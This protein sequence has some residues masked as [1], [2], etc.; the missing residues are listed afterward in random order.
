[1]AL[2]WPVE[3]V[4]E[5]P[6]TGDH[7]WLDRALD[8]PRF[9]IWKLT[10]GPVP[11]TPRFVVG[12]GLWGIG[13]ATQDTVFHALIS[14]YLPQ[15]RRATA[16]GLFDAVRGTAWLAGSVVLGL[17]YSVS[18]PGLVAASLVLQLAAL[19]VLLLRERH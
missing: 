15:D 6:P 1:M 19:P 3:N 5:A 10:D 7:D 2:T 9:E 16:Y 12:V 11:G 18:L 17:L 4:L 8:C 14:R 13:T